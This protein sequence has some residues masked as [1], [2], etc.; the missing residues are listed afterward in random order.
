MCLYRRVLLSLTFFACVTNT[1]AHEEKTLFNQVHVQAQVERDIPND[2][3][4]SLLVSE[5]QGKNA[6]ELSARVNQDIKWAVA[7]AKKHADIKVSTRAYQTFP[8]YKERDVVGWRVSQ[9][10]LLKSESMT[11]LSE[12]IGGLQKKLQVTQM[13]LSASKQTRD[14]IENELIEEAMQ[15]FKRRAAIIKKHM[16]DKDY[17]I[18]NLHVNSNGQQPRMTHAQRNRMQAME[19]ASAPTVE[20]GTS[21]ITVT[22][23]GSV[24][25]F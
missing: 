7:L 1:A 24:H 4:Q 17:R 8:I 2:E 21:K 5:H 25:F 16:D 19:M 13:Q 9:E 12:V 11:V 3:M 10:V 20:A 14:K 18:V 6:S 22:V 23:S 15:A